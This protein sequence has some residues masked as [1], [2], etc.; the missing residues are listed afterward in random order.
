[1]VRHSFLRRKPL[2]FLFPE[3]GLFSPARDRTGRLE[4]D[5]SGNDAAFPSVRDAIRPPVPFDR[6]YPSWPSNSDYAKSN[7]SRASFPGDGSAVPD[8]GGGFTLP[9]PDLHQFTTMIAAPL[10]IST[11]SGRS[12]NFAGFKSR[13]L[14][15]MFSP[16]GG[17]SFD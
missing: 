5:H 16:T 11:R 2:P 13:A 3:D 14:T 15:H 10:R 12:G 1:M 6:T 8:I 9:R 4:A 7:S 17:F